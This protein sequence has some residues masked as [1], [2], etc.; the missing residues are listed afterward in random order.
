[1]E[2]KI[3][4]VMKKLD[5]IIDDE[6]EVFIYEIAKMQPFTELMDLMPKEHDHYNE[7]YDEYIRKCQ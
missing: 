1:M 5:W 6:D 4:S 7:L 2:S 3:L